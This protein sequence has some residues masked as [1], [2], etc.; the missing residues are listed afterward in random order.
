ML[1]KGTPLQIHELVNGWNINLMNEFVKN[2]DNNFFPLVYSQFYEDADVKKDYILFIGINPSDKGIPPNFKITNPDVSIEDVIKYENDALMNYSY[3][4]PLRDISKE[5]GLPFKHIDLFF[6]RE[7]KQL[8]LKKLIGLR[9]INN[10]EEVEINDIG[11]SQLEIFYELLKKLK[12]KVI[13]I[14][15]AT[16]SHI[17][18][19]THKT[20]YED[21]NVNWQDDRGYHIYKD[22]KRKLSI[23][24]FSS[25]MLSGG[26]ALDI[27]S[28]QRL[29]WHI[30]KSI[31]K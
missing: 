20:Y 18:H 31:T 25:G 14:V 15:N 27:Y 6:I 13:V 22:E 16:A 26:R 10:R 11:N 4:A 21:S 9:F 28:R 29:I 8:E 2:I 7:R 19:A 23:P 24:L 17:F 5:I 3:F 30:K 12:P 1:I